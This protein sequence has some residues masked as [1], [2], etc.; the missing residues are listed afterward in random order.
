MNWIVEACQVLFGQSDAEKNKI[1]EQIRQ[2]QWKNRKICERLPKLVT[3]L[4]GA[5][6]SAKKGYEFFDPHIPVAEKS[7]RYYTKKDIDGI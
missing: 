4:I 5:R 1:H 3:T 6:K 7:S 2:I